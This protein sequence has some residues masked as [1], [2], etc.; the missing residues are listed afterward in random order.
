MSEA[1]ERLR[2]SVSHLQDT[3]DELSHQQATD[4]LSFEERIKE[5]EEQLCSKESEHCSIVSGL[6]EELSRTSIERDRLS[7]LVSQRSGEPA[8]SHSS[9]ESESEGQ[10]A[11]GFER[12]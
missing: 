10:R 9:V 1:N 7:E 11:L 6:E 3:N 4:K 8:E 5:L 2:D 12:Q